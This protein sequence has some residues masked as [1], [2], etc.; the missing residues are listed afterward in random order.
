MLIRVFKP[1]A[2]HSMM[3]TTTKT[4][5]EERREKKETRDH[6]NYHS[7]TLKS[8]STLS[9]KELKREKSSRAYRYRSIIKLGVE[10]SSG[11]FFDILSLVFG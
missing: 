3:M 4:E 10:E 11:K 7:T 2:E 5:K 6:I 9:L 1:S 8:T